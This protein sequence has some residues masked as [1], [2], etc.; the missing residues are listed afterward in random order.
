MQLLLVMLPPRS[1]YCDQRIAGLRRRRGTNFVVNYLELMHPKEW[2]GN[3]SQLQRDIRRS[4]FP[5]KKINPV[6]LYRSGSAATPAN[7]P[8]NWTDQAP[9]TIATARAMTPGLQQRSVDKLLLRRLLPNTDC[10]N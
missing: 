3:L 2:P 6:D 5:E 10:A 8:E 1:I 7:G 9:T 4:H